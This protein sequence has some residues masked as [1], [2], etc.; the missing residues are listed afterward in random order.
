[1]IC[2]DPEDCSGLKER[3]KHRGIKPIPRVRRLR[4]DK[5][6]L[7]RPKAKGLP[8][9]ALKLLRGTESP[10]NFLTQ[11]PVRARRE[12]LSTD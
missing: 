5:S 7:R 2:F 9:V 3:C 8:T 4:P 11:G 12:F 1:M 10:G 6:G